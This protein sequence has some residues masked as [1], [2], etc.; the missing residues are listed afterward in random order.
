MSTK[1]SK[2]G[3]TF[4]EANHLTYATTITNWLIEYQNEN[5]NNINKPMRESVDLRGIYAFCGDELIGGLT[6]TTRYEWVFLDCGFVL[7]EYR[8]Q[9]IYKDIMRSIERA[10]RKEGLC[11]V[12]VS[13]Y[14]FEAPYIYESLGYTKGC[15]LRNLPKGNTSI[16]Y[17]K[18]FDL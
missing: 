17:Y 9:G 8:N 5:G 12:W 7:P 14:E 10:A 3:I 1:M 2:N 15:I 6:F 16:D 18:C 4:I 11:G 13:T